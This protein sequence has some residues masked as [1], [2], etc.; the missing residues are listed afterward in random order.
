MITGCPVFFGHLS[1]RI[2][3][4]RARPEGSSG[5][6]AFRPRAVELR[7]HVAPI[8]SMYVCAAFGVVVSASRDGR[9][10]VWDLNTLSY[11]RTIP[12]REMLAVTSVTASETLCDV[13]SVHDFT[14]YQMDRQS[15]SDD[16]EDYEKNGQY[17]FKSLIRV[18]TINGTFVGSVKVVEKVNC[19]CYSNAPEGISVNCIAVGLDT[20][21][22]RLFSSWDLRPVAYIAPVNPG[23]GLMSQSF[24]KIFARSITYSVD[25]QQLFA[26][27][28]DGA[29]IAWESGTHT[30]P[31]SVRILSAHAIF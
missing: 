2:A 13:A 12:N 11:V 28:A 16:T 14:S 25:S 5:A 23:I 20:G 6:C 31:G 26:G 8:V 3:V 22:I 9:I 4:I 29:V 30:R 10:V 24:T 18:H 21:A 27:R 7:A 1:G 15:S 19:V 17:K